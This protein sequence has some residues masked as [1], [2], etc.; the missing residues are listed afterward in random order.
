[1]VSHRWQMKDQ[2]GEDR[3]RSVDAKPCGIPNPHPTIHCTENSICIHVYR[4]P[5][6]PLTPSSPHK[7]D[8]ILQT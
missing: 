6:G 7:L 8:V 1:M 3:I 5:T 4:A 2:N